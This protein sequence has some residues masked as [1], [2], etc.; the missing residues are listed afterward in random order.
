MTFSQTRVKAAE[1]NG[2]P[3]LERLLKLAETGGGGQ[4]HRVAL[5]LGACW[6]GRRH[7]D[8][9]DFRG[10]DQQIGDDLMAVLEW[11]RLGNVDIGNMIPDAHTRIVD[12]LTA[13]GMYGDD[14]RGQAIAHDQ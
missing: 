10:F 1:K 7:F 3:A 5:F 11:H 8:F 6:N 2:R 13:W 4:V 14:Q 12:V 9:Y